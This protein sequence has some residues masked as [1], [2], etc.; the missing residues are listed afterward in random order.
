[1]ENKIVLFEFYDLKA[2]SYFVYIKTPIGLLYTEK[3]PRQFHT[4]G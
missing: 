2:K 3:V 4:V 1:M